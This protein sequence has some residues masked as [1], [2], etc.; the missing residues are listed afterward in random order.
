MLEYTAELYAWLE[1]GAHLYVCG[2]AS[3]MAKDVDAAL[4][5]I[6]AHAGRKSADEAAAYVQALKASKRYARDVY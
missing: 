6:V 2:D 5:Q 1:A 3:R 4:H